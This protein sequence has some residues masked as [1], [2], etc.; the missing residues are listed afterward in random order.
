MS[1]NYYPQ[2][3]PQDWLAGYEVRDRQSG[4]LVLGVPTWSMPSIEPVRLVVAEMCA[5][6]RCCNYAYKG[7]QSKAIQTSLPLPLCRSHWLDLWAATRGI[8]PSAHVDP[9]TG[10]GRN[11]VADEPL[12]TA[13]A[14]IFT[15]TFDDAQQHFLLEH[16]Q[17][18]WVSIQS[19]PND[20][21]GVHWAGVHVHP[22]GTYL[23]VD[24]SALWPL[25]A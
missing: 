3:A 18:A 12:L 11:P 17:G 15:L 21:H 8:I 14:D 4:V 25:Q 19:W 10:A 24:G 16:Y 1:T 7:T 13:P 6:T 2:H 20:D 22:V 5:A 23:I 9:T